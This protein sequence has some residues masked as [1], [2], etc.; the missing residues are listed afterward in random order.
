MAHIGV[1]TTALLLLATLGRTGSIG[2]S[3]VALDGAWKDAHD[4]DAKPAELH[5]QHIAHGS[6]RSLGC[7]VDWEYEIVK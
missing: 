6:D 3:N 2:S 4:P 5:S 1:C 7:A